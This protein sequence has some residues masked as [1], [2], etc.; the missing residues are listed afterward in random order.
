MGLFKKIMN[1]TRKPQGFLGGMML[2]GMNNGHAKVA[3]WGL[4]H[5]T[6]IAPEKILEVGCGGGRNA[7]Q[8][9]QKYPSSKLTAVDY[10]ETSLE[11]TKQFNS[12]MIKKG[13]CN[14]QKGDVSALN[15]DE[16][17]DL[18]T[19]FETIYFW[20]GLEKCFSEV[21]KALKPGGTF[22]IVNEATGDDQASLK[23]EKMVDGMK[24]HTVNEI[25]SALSVAGF[26]KI[27]TDRHESK[28]WVTVIAK[29]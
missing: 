4:A 15:I 14:V 22:M 26:S 6:T 8:L 11:K 17:Y 24:C 27:K 21:N 13:R 25:E 23:Y 19:A 29:K 28:P 5:L 12:E 2:D 16:Q 7:Y 9:L 18:A 10:S 3:D 1:Q 20:P